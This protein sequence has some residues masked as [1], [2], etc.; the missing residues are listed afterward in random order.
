[1][2]THHEP[3]PSVQRALDAYASR[4]NARPIHREDEHDRRTVSDRAAAL[5]AWAEAEHTAQEK[6]AECAKPPEG[7]RHRISVSVEVDREVF[8]ALRLSG[9]RCWHYIGEH[10]GWIYSPDHTV[11]WISIKRRVRP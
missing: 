8:D 10:A 4:F 6:D 2:S 5:V 11:A 1:M 7:D 3:D 9:R